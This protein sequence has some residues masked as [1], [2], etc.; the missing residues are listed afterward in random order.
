MLLQVVGT[1]ALL[2]LIYDGDVCYNLHYS[3]HNS[4]KNKKSQYALM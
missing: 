2:I 3:V 4:A 1:V